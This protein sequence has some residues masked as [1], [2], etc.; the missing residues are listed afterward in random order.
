MANVT[1]KTATGKRLKR[2]L[3]GFLLLVGITNLPWPSDFLEM[4]V[5][6]DHYQ[7]SNGDGT[8]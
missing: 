3:L 7:Y 4:W 2:V 8:W 6:A 1:K 5:D